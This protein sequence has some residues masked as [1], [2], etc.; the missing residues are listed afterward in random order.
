M[1]HHPGILKLTEI[2]LRYDDSVNWQRKVPVGKGA[3]R[4]A[5]LNGNRG[6]GTLN[7]WS[8]VAVFSIECEG[9]EG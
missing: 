2:A 8:L 4:Q 6:A 9:C 7:Y 5:D 1:F 3:T